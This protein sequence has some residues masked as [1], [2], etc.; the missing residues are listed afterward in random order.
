VNTCTR[1]RRANPCPSPAAA[2][3]TPYSHM[4]GPIPDGPI[5]DGPADGSGAGPDATGS[6]PPRSA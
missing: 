4:S 6:L 5:P 3:G 2:A 1:A